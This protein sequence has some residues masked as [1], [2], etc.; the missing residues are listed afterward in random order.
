ME[1]STGPPLLI[2][3]CR[4]L[5]L[6]CQRWIKSSA[7]DM[8]LHLQCNDI[9]KAVKLIL[10]TGLKILYTVRNCCCRV[11]KVDFNS[12]ASCTKGSIFYSVQNLCFHLQMS[13]AIIALSPMCVH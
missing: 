5:Q 2:F 13:L 6:H 4:Y 10:N 12:K 9:Q 8:Q 11:Q 7:Q 1:K 3:E